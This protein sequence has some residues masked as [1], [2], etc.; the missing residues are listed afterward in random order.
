MLFS[1]VTIWHQIGVHVCAPLQ[2]VCAIQYRGFLTQNQSACRKTIFALFSLA[3]TY[4]ESN[5]YMYVPVAGVFVAAM[6]VF[7]TM[8]TMK[9]M[10]LIL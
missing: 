4:L 7:S 5:V 8:Q 6:L 2:C 10:S 3:T 1:E 9:L